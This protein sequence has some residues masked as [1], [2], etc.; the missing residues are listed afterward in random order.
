VQHHVGERLLHDANDGRL[1]HRRQLEARRDRLVHLEACRSN[2]P[3]DLVDARREVGRGQGGGRIRVAAQNPY[4]LPHRGERLLAVAGDPANGRAQFL[5]S[6][7]GD[8]VGCLGADDHRADMVGDDVVDVASEGRALLGG[9]TRDVC[10]AQP[11]QLGVA[12]PQGLHVPTLH[13]HGVAEEHR[14]S[15][16]ESG[17]HARRWIFHVLEEVRQRFEKRRI[18]TPDPRWEVR[19]H[20]E[21]DRRRNDDEKPCP[22]RRREEGGDD[23]GDDAQ[24][25]H[26]EVPRRP[27]REHPDQEQPGQWREPAH[28]DRQ[29]GEDAERLVVADIGGV[30][31]QLE[32]DEDDEHPDDDQEQTLEHVSDDRPARI[33]GGHTRPRAGVDF[34][35]EDSSRG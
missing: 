25:R 13:P 7:V 5:R 15:D 9:D 8:A 32:T 29:P 11:H 19:Q 20:H 18:L 2:A 16:N 28:R 33:G 30:P 17:E 34:R 35:T 22:C 4:D 6:R 14:A 12:L 3:H 21:D 10:G 26:L 24:L 27:R 23:D 31:A 1:Q